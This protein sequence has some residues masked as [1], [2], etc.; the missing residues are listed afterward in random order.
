MIAAVLAQPDACPSCQ[1]GIPEAAAPA[2]PVED[3]DGGTLAS[4][5]CASCG[6]AWQTLFDR[7]GWIVERLVA[8]VAP[9]ANA[10]GWPVTRTEAA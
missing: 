1:P 10:T 2:G 3:V 8:P 5:E 9:D 6:T 7:Y 4:Y